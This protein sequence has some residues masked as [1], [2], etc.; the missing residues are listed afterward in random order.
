MPRFTSK[1]I[2]RTEIAEGTLAFGFERPAGF[3]FTAGQFVTLTLPDPLYNDAKGS[4]RTFS[5]ASP[6]QETDRL[7]VAT[8]LTGS[9][10]KRSLAEAPLGAPVSIFGP[11]GDFTLPA[12]AAIPLV[13]I[14]GGIGITP[15]RSMVLDAVSQRRPHRIMLIYSNRTPE[16]AAFHD[17]LARV[18]AA[19]PSFRYLP[20]MT[21]AENVRQPWLGERRAVSAAFLRD[22]I[23]DIASPIFFV[24]GPSGLVAAV[25]EAV[26]A[27]GAAPAHV[28]AE[29]FAG[30]EKPHVE[31]GSAAGPSRTSF[32]A[33]AQQ[34]D[35]APGQVKAVA[36]N[37]RQIVLCNVAG[38]FYALADECPHA[39][40]LLSEGELVGQSIV[41]PLHGAAF[42][43]ATGA[44][45][46]PP[47][48]EGVAGYAV[49]VVGGAIEVEI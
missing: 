40:G 42:D 47:A 37:G 35:L 28:R 11:A 17:E 15:F 3:A 20:T 10:F 33:V 19:H 31:T 14:A 6:P 26:L 30:Y 38:R 49:R 5:I 46:E 27:A 24:A 34:R 8:R 43:V 18:A 16:G 12:D 39:G 36:A 7:L 22:C 2:E 45:L 23:E 4:S 1:L 21:Q 9:A 41:C 29:E 25:T 32:V 48:D 13:F 44:V